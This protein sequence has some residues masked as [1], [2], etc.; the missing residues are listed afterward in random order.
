MGFTEVNKVVEIKCDNESAVTI[1]NTGRTSEQFLN[2]CLWNL[3]FLAAYYNIDLRVTHIK[4]VV[5]TQADAFS[6]GRDVSGVT[7]ETFKGY[8]FVFY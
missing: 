5:N 6:R 1:C 4:G 8:V 3:W 7:L 2:L